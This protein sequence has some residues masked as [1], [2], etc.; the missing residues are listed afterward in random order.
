[1]WC[2]LPAECDAGLAITVGR[3]WLE[4]LGVATKTA[5]RGAETRT[6]CTT[7][8]A[9]VPT[10]TVMAGPGSVNLWLRSTAPDTDVAVTLTELRPDGQEL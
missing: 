7:G 8:V 10:T 2:F 6:A 1:M 3:G 4:A 5:R 9:W